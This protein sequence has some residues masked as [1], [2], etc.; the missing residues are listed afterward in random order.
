MGSDKQRLITLLQ[1]L[2]YSKRKVT[3]ASGR[4]SDF[5][6]DG[7]QTTLHAEGAAIIGR[8]V[9]KILREGAYDGVGGL[10]MGAD[11][12]S[13][14]AS[15]ASTTD[16]GP[17]IHAFYVRK[18]AKGHG[19]G[20]FIEGLR[21]LP[22]GSRVAVV[23]DTS[24]TGGSAYKAVERARAV[25]FEVPVVITIVDREE[26]AREFLEGKGLE[27]RSLVTRTELVGGA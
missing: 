25:G 5:Y 15:I 9:L 14:A 22:K 13:T 27:V 7:K 12:I 10:S 17:L 16:G 23:E 6:I 26:G 4:E 8:M 1:E 20:A 24:T 21:N 3:L 2:S 18:E 11:P 19:T